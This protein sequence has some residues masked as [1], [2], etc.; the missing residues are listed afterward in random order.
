MN[1]YRPRTVSPLSQLNDG[2]LREQREMQAAP[3]PVAKPVVEP[4]AMDVVFDIPGFSAITL[5]YHDVIDND[6]FVV[7]VYDSNW[8]GGRV[9]FPPT[10]DGADP[11]PIAMAVPGAGYVYSVHT[12]G[13]QFAHENWEYCVLTVATRVPLPQEQ[14]EAWH[15]HGKESGS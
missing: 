6:G 13:V 7:L 14:M 11:A 8:S 1:T 9:T 5:K 12:T 15:D 2:I 4:P 10:A 3:A